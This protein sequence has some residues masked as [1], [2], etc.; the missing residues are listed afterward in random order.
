MKE[1]SEIE[2]IG[3]SSQI[4]IEVRQ[5]DGAFI[6]TVDYPESDLQEKIVLRQLGDKFIRDYHEELRILYPD[7]NL[8]SRDAKK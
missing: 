5:S 3:L 2:K 6:I 1:I 4:N 7:K 8:P